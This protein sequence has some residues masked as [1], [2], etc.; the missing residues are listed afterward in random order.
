MATNHDLHYADSIYYH[1]KTVYYMGEVVEDNVRHNWLPLNVWVYLAEEDPYCYE[2]LT[3][4][5]WWL[6]DKAFKEHCLVI[7]K[8][9]GCIYTSHR[10]ITNEIEFLRVKSVESCLGLKG[11]RISITNGQ[12]GWYQVFKYNTSLT[13]ANGKLLAVFKNQKALQLH[14]AFV[15]LSLW[16][17]GKGFHNDLLI[18]GLRQWIHP[19]WVI[20]NSGAKLNNLLTDMVW[21]NQTRKILTAVPKSHL[22]HGR[23]NTLSTMGTTILFKGHSMSATISAYPGHVQLGRKGQPS[24]C[25]PVHLGLLKYS[26]PEHVDMVNMEQSLSE[27]ILSGVENMMSKLV[28]NI[29][30]FIT[31]SI[32]TTNFALLAISYYVARRLSGS[33]ILGVIFASW[34]RMALNN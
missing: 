7:F 13:T 4:D 28:N 29:V 24:L 15:H 32:A 23:C 22:V 30:S 2:E 12:A 8:K 31:Q 14:G 16:Y 1:G 3:Y 26:K 5:T 25:D 10:S 21:L 19:H 20:L 9:L 6:G 33:W 18:D 34:I 11:S 17:D 27:Q